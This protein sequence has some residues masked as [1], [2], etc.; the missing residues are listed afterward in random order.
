MVKLFT[1]LMK[2]INKPKNTPLSKLK[3]IFFGVV[4]VLHFFSYA[5]VSAGP[6][7]SPTDTPP[8]TENFPNLSDPYLILSAHYAAIGGL[9]RLKSEKTSFMHGKIRFAEMDGE[10]KVW[11]E[12]IQY[13]REVHYPAFSQIEGDNGRHMWSVDLNNKHLVHKDPETL[14]RR[15]IRGLL[16]DFEN[17]N[18]NSEFFN[19]SFMGVQ[20]VNGETCYVIETRNTINRDIYYD[21]FSVKTFFLLKE[22]IKQPYL[23]FTTF[24]RDFRKLNEMTYAFKSETE[25]SPTGKKILIQTEEIFINLPIDHEKYE[26]PEKDVRDFTFANN[27][28]AEALPFVFV[29]NNIFLPVTIQG[30]THYWVLDS[31]ADMSVIDADYADTLGLLPTGVL[32]GNATSS[33]AEFSFVNLGAYQLKGLELF[34]QTILSYKG[35][36]SKFYD[37]E[38]MGILGYD[39]LSR[40]ITKVDYSNQHVSFYDPDNFVYKG[41]GHRV[42]APLQNKLFMLPMKIDEN[43]K[44][45][46]GLDLGSFDVSMNYL[47]AKRNNF[48]T[49]AGIQRLSSDISGIFYEFQIKSQSMEIAGYR[50]NNELITFPIKEGIGSNSNEEIDGLIGNTL[51]RHF[52]LYLDYKNQQLIF[53]KGDDFDYEFPVDKSGMI[54]GASLNNLPQ[55]FY[56]AEKTPAF[57]AGILPGDIIVGIN[58]LEGETLPGIVQIIKLLQAESGTEYKLKLLRDTQNITINLQLNELYK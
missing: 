35:L 45:R 23:E 25:I 8:Q 58:G 44:G 42:D 19:L 4:F 56:V 49:T 48:M 11:S 46:F 6:Q 36:A 39:F 27:I 10:L 30:E 16:E 13:R 53:E 28:N 37:P 54:V 12:G 51:L 50:V 32:F 24:Y 21:C 57:I 9:E 47:F 3:Y 22:I 33:L 5:H 34:D 1:Y 15:K 26:L 18:P 43:F 55:V 2:S 38:I 52:T 29:E 17:F 31:G 7:S 20:E 14:K 40:F 41:S